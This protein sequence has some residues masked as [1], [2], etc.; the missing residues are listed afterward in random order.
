MNKPPGARSAAARKTPKPR[1][2][3]VHANAGGVDVG[4]TELYAALPAERAET[5]VRRLSTFTEDLYELA[6][7]FK[8]H[9]I[10]SVAMESTG[11]FWIPVFQVLESCGL[12]VCL[13]N[14]RHVKNVPGRKT[15]VQDCQWL[16][17]LHSVG[18]LQ[19]SFRP[20]DE[21]CAVRSLLRHRANLVA[22]GAKHIQH[23]QKSLNQMNLHL[24]HVL[25]D[26]SGLS[27][28][29]IVDALLAGERAPK[30]L[31]RLREPGTKAS[32]E[33]MIKALTG[34]YRSEHLFT[35]KQA[36]AAYRFCRE[37]LEECDREIERLLRGLATA[38]DPEEAPPPPPATP[39]S[40]PRKGQIALPNH[41]L[42]TELYRILGTDLTQVPGFQ[43][44]NVCALLAELGPD[45]KA[46]PDADHFVSW[47]G[48]CPNPQISG[49]KVLRRGTRHV[50]H[51]VATIFRIA[52]QTLHHNKSALGEFYRRQRSKLGAPK[53][54][55]AAAHKLARLFYCLVTNRIEYDDS[56]FAKNEELHQQRRLKRLQREAAELGMALTAT[57]PMEALSA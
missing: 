48:L 32:E 14:A 6:A 45:L 4:A 25:S 53:A 56:V 22:E 49:G 2:R 12:E 15:D 37:Q 34:D 16:Q 30:V 23:M 29:N 55:T 44:S 52:A 8:E 5:T 46:F 10:T 9:G 20:S 51:R 38:V 7:W 39:K 3:L 33:T 43:V 36:R 28:L 17:Y 27:G 13:V 41:D 26:L 42:R 19:A 18:L 21:I 40:K 1:L 31:A 47:L 57:A 54:I 35:L 50:K 11:V 24:H